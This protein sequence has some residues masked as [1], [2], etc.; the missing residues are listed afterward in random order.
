MF[1]L[2]KDPD[3]TMRS[4][5]KSLEPRPV[6]LMLCWDLFLFM[7]AFPRKNAAMT[8]A[9][10]MM[11]VLRCCF[12][13]RRISTEKVRKRGEERRFFWGGWGTW[14]NDDLAGLDLLGWFL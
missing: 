14:E 10:A 2:E 6:T 5:V 9:S 1:F 3:Q 12:I 8:T 7:N 11:V 13:R 4:D